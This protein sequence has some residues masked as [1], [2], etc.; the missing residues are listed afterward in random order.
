MGSMGLNSTQAKSLSLGG[1]IPASLILCI[2]WLLDTCTYLF[3]LFEWFSNEREMIFGEVL[4]ENRFWTVTKKIL[5]NSQN[6]ILRSQFLCM[7]PRLLSNFHQL[8]TFRAEQ[9]KNFLKIDY[10]TA[11]KF[12][13]FLLLCVYVTLLVFIFL[14]LLCFFPKT[15]KDQKYFCCFSSPFVY[16]GFLL[17]FC[18]ICYCWFAIRKSKKILLCLLVSFCSCFQFENTKNICCSSLVCKVH[19]EFNGLRWLERGFHFILSKLHK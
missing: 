1:G 13:E 14:F 8:N 6:V 12:D 19:Y 17:L 3:S 7:F 2:L 9:R 16:F 18:F 4:P 10:C 15:Q 11:V 5:K